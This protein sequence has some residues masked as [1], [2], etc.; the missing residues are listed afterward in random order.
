MWQVMA[1]EEGGEAAGEALMLARCVSIVKAED[2]EDDVLE[3]GDALE[4]DL[5]QLNTITQADRE[6]VHHQAETL[7]RRDSLERVGR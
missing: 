5:A 6:Q 7:I 2:D 3:E 4:G 1:I